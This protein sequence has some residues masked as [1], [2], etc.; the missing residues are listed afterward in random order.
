[1]T[2][3][4]FGADSYFG[5]C[6]ICG[7]FQEFVQAS[8]AI[9]EGY[10]CLA[11]KGSLREREQA[12]SILDCY[13][14]LRASTLTDL[15]SIDEF[16][17]L[18]IYE[19][20]TIG[21]FRK[22]FK[23]LPHYN[24]SDYYAE[25]DRAMATSQV[26]HQNLEDLSYPDKSFDLIVNSDILEHVRKPMKA[27]AEI[28]RVLKPGG[29]HVFTVPLQEPLATKT[30]AR[31]DTSGEEDIHILPEHYHGNGKGGRSL[32]YTDF[33]KDITDMLA[34]VG[35]SAFLRRSISESQEANRV[36]TVIARRPQLS[37]DQL[38]HPMITGEPDMKTQTEACN[39][40][41]N[42]SFRPAPFNRISVTGK[43][44]LCEKCGSLERHRIFRVMFN[45]IRT[46]EFQK[47]SCLQ[48][49]SD[50]SIALGW[51]A[52]ATRSMHGGENHLDIQNIA[53]ADGSFDVVVCNHILEHVPDYKVA[54]R[55][56][57]R[58]TRSTG[59]VFLSFP[60]P[61]LRKVTE[62]W[63]FPRPEQHGHYRVFGRDIEGVFREF[64]RNH[65]VLALEG[66][67]PVTGTSDIAYILTQSSTWYNHIIKN[68]PKT[69]IIE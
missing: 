55:E 57:A 3:S 61:Y 33:G 16:R 40:C 56:V 67:D 54:I 41:G 32:V 58:I 59:F 10:R 53:H 21:A 13:S 19:P 38:Q 30:V 8:R 7:Q 60:N 65:H 14:E 45:N 42:T 47:Y 12:Q 11:C 5:R 25:S 26:P 68:H 43:P 46:P 9:R 63:G 37:I 62:D 1:M 36:L 28:F 48:F 39:I 44:P 6:S 50:P 20:G 51:F 22:L 66:L 24:Q 29:Y 49:S 23:P 17:C 52:D 4:A 31:V 69:T 15:V 2:D 34:A 64:L 27:F 35:F 18:K